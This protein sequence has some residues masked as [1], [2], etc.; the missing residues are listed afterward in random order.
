MLPL[1]ISVRIAGQKKINRGIILVNGA[2]EEL[3]MQQRKRHDL[4]CDQ[5]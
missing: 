5:Q 2:G 4:F 1:A 3:G